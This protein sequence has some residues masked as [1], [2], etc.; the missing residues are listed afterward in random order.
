MGYK[1]L[2]EN[3]LKNYPNDLNNYYLLFWQNT[4]DGIVFRDFDF[5]TKFEY[6]EEAEIKN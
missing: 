5:V 4:K 6:N 1:E 2:I 3:L